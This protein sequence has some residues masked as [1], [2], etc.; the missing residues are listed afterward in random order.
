MDYKIY[1]N[2]C[3][4]ADAEEKELHNSR[5]FRRLMAKYKPVKLTEK[6][7]EEYVLSDKDIDSKVIYVV[8]E[9]KALDQH[10]GLID[11]LYIMIVRRP[12]GMP[13][14]YL[15]LMAA[16]DLEYGYEYCPSNFENYGYEEFL[17]YKEK[18][19]NGR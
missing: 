15:A 8:R 7:F 13:Q 9:I 12:K 16:G 11:A 6:E 19:A 5:V 3:G 4:D 17:I 18:V 2:Y 14:E 10:K 1:S